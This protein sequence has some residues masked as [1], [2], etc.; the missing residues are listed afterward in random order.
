MKNCARTNKAGRQSLSIQWSVRRWTPT[1]N[2]H[3]VVENAACVQRGLPR[4][5]PPVVTR[6][7]FN[8][9]WL[10]MNNSQSARGPRSMGFT[11]IELLVV[12]SIIGILAA[13]VLPA[14]GK[15]K[16]SA[17]VAKAKTEIK[18]IE[19]AISQYQATY[20]RM[21]A[22]RKAR[23]NV[24]E[25]NPD[26]TFG[27]MHQADPETGSTILL[28]EKK[29]DGD[30]NDNNTLAKIAAKDGAGWQNSNAEVVS[31]LRDITDFR[32]LKSVAW[33][34][35]HALN[36]QRISFLNAKEV[37]GSFEEPKQQISGIGLDGIYRDPWGAPYII[38]LDLNY[39]GQTRDAFYK[40][41]RVSRDGDSGLRGLNGFYSTDGDNFDLR[42]PIMV[43][44]FGP[45]AAVDFEKKAN[46]GANKDN[47]TSW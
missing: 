13:L 18:D 31:I 33:N 4:N 14:I 16:V 21:P 28:P 37:G 32:N 41:P 19:G 15:A 9:N 30:G 38:T 45:D 23:E 39:D 27:T 36:P 44:S 12:I 35:N 25:A 42:Q 2:Q 10:L 8:L 22:S 40:S 47:V 46:A 43:W 29:D 26:F 3:E 20:S 1:I 6:K 17:Q 11:L 24:N 7:S 34:Q 5:C